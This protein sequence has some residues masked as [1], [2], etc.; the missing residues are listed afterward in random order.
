M[1]LLQHEKV[2][3]YHPMDDSVE[4][5]QGL[6]WTLGDDSSF[7]P[8]GKVGGGLQV[9]AGT[10][11][12]LGRTT[13][14]PAT[15]SYPGG[16]DSETTVAMAFWIENYFTAGDSKAIFIGYG[17]TDS[18][19][20]WATGSNISI[21]K[22][23]SL[24]D[25]TWNPNGQFSGGN[26]FISSPPAEGAGWHFV[27]VDLRT[28]QPSGKWRIRTSFDGATWT[29]EGLANTTTLASGTHGRT[30]VQLSRPNSGEAA[31]T[32]DE[33]AVWSGQDLF[34]SEELANLY[35]LGE[36]FGLG[37][38]QYE[39]QYGAPICWQATA[40]MPDGAVWHDSG[41]GPC[42]ATVRVPPGASDVVVTDGGKLANPRVIEG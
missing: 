22:Q 5:L 9:G 32:I 40:M 25:V 30:Y 34:T 42:P 33:L 27:V 26:R 39:Q 37:L 16:F 38:D 4:S 3:Y 24:Y 10:G 31:I 8:S 13:Y 1:T 18:G 36:T 7:V 29:D 2:H 17:G 23:G 41:S 20:G 11:T 21:N 12:T 28:E 6:A 35:D 14:S 15:P 19:S